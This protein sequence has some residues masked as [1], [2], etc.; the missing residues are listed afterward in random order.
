M[1]HFRRSIGRQPL[2]ATLYRREDRCLLVVANFLRRAVGCKATLDFDALGIPAAARDGMTVVDVDHARPPDGADLG[3]LHLADNVRKPGALPV[4]GDSLDG[5]D[6][7]LADTRDDADVDALLGEDEEAKRARKREQ[8]FA[9]AAQGN[10]I[11][12]RVGA[13]NYRA[14]EWRWA[15]AAG[16]EGGNRRE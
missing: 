13:H 9:I 16:R 3:V 4:I 12:L 7:V 8:F 6:S 14:V 1:E 10:E 11:S 2:R 5:P 15:E